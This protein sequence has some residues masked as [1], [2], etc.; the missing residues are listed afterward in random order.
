MFHKKRLFIAVTCTV[1]EII[2][3][4]NGKLHLDRT[5]IHY[6]ESVDFLCDDGY[7]R[8]TEKQII[9]LSNNTWSAYPECQKKGSNF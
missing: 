3:I 2:N 8:S 4:A 5:Q 7:S 6:G 1:D 9:C